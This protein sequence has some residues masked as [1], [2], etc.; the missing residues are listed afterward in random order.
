MNRMSDPL[1]A[2]QQQIA[3]APAS[4]AKPGGRQGG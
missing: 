3:P 4:D 1:D 2:I